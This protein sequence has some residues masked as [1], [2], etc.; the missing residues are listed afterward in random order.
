MN[1]MTPAAPTRKVENKTAPDFREVYTNYSEI[2]YTLMDFLLKFS[3]LRDA[4]PGHV[5]LTSL[6]HVA[7]SPQ[8]AK[9]AH[10][11]LGTM[12]AAYEKQHGVIPEEKTPPG[13]A[14]Q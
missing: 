7:M 8:Q 9:A 11:A 4:T 5:V 3:V 6:L 14:L 10:R 13:T 2:A 12:L 1:A